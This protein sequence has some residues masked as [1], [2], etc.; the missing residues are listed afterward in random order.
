MNPKDPGTL[1]KTSQHILEV[2]HY[3]VY[4]HASQVITSLLICEY[5]L[6]PRIFYL[7]KEIQ[8]YNFF[9]K[10]MQRKVKIRT[11]LRIYVQSDM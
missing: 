4:S 5:C 1:G 6:R 7:C 2:Q 8:V 9:Q 11:D 3:T 10:S